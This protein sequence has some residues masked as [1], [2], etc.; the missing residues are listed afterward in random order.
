VAD[1]LPRQLAAVNRFLQSINAGNSQP[2]R[3]TKS[4]L[5]PQVSITF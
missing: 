3:G 1:T 5:M 4:H 2:S